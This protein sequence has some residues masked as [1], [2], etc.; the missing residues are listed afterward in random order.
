MNVNTILTQD[1]RPGTII[2]PFGGE[3]FDVEQ[4]TVTA[5]G[6]VR[7]VNWYGEVLRMS[8][9]MHVQVLGHFNPDER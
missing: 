9:G 5:W 6:E 8:D 1:I 2:R 3:R 7:M 4:V